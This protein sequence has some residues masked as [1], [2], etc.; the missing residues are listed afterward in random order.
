MVIYLPRADGREATGHAVGVDERMDVFSIDR[1]VFVGVSAAV[2]RTA[3]YRFLLI[4]F[5]LL[6]VFSASDEDRAGIF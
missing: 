2:Q 6:V 3:L 1:G 4:F 5:C